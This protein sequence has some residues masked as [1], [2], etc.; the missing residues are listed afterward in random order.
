MLTATYR[1][2]ESP[3]LNALNSKFTGEKLVVTEGSKKKKTFT[4]SN[5]NN[6]SSD[7]EQIRTDFPVSLALRA[8]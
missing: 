5:M 7:P 2:R 6:R 8:H 3:H 1:Q 4:F